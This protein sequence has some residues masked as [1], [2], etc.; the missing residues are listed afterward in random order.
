MTLPGGHESSSPPGIAEELPRH[1]MLTVDE[2]A[3]F[4]RMD[5]KSVYKAVHERELPAVRVRGRFRVPRAAL[6][7]WI[8]AQGRAASPGDSHGGTTK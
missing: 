6:L 1:A 2:I 3:A 7:I 4:L 5:R 8:D